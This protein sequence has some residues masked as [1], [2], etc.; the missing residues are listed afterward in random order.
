MWRVSGVEVFA[1]VSTSNNSGKRNTL[2]ACSLEA[3]TQAPFGSRYRYSTYISPKL[4]HLH[5]RQRK[6]D[7]RMIPAILYHSSM[8]SLCLNFRPARSA[9]RKQNWFPYSSNSMCGPSSTV[10]VPP[11]SSP[12]TPASASASTSAS[13]AS[14]PFVPEFV[15]EPV[16]ASAAAEAERDD[17]DSDSV[18]HS[19]TANA[20]TDPCFG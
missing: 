12:P 1:R 7:E 17:S 3:L 9:A 18:L 11:V 13:A 5:T 20:K 2:S 10:L 8:V 6:L 15:P 4:T 19:G 14:R 16:A